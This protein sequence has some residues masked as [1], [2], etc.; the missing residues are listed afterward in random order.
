MRKCVCLYF[1]VRADTVKPPE[2]WTMNKSYCKYLIVMT[3]LTTTAMIQLIQN[4]AVIVL[5]AAEKYIL[6]V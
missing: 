4:I 5:P 6:C 1:E 3:I 2:Q